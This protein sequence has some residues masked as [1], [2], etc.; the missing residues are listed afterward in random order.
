V[1]PGAHRVVLDLDLSTEVADE[2]I[3]RD[4]LGGTHV[5]GCDDSQRGAAPFKVKQLRLDDSQSIPLDEGAQ[6]VDLIGTV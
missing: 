3:Q 6:Q 4:P 1:K 5:R 2:A